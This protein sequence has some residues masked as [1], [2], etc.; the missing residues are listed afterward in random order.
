MATLEQLRRRIR[1]AEDLLSVVGIM[2][3]LAAAKIREF[4]RAADS[5]AEYAEVVELGFRML[6]RARPDAFEAGVAA[7][8]G[9]PRH[10]PRVVVMLG[11][12]QG[13]V[14]RFNDEIVECARELWS[15]GDDARPTLIAV[16]ERLVG[17]LDPRADAAISAPSDAAGI[18]ARVAEIL[19]AIEATTGHEAPRIT[20]AHHRRAEGTAHRPAT[21]RLTPLDPEWIVRLRALGWPY[22]GIPAASLTTPALIRALVRAHLLVSF[23]RALAESLAAENARRLATMQAAERN[24]GER[25][26]R[27]TAEYRQ[28][29]QTVITAELLEVSAGFEVIEG[30]GRSH[31]G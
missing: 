21:Q 8:V 10:A 22:R 14:G 25:I 5:L 27:L 23:Q 4:E 6:L 11:S 1:T 29:R 31:G 7:H 30:E 18:V 17:Q 24:V 19:V 3:S 2:K 12:E 13:M 20:I 16:G 15:S 9:E 26:D 28:Q